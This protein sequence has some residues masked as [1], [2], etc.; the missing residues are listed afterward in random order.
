[1]DELRAKL[2]SDELGQH[3]MDVE[4]LLQKHAL[5]E[6]DLNIIADHVQNV[7]RQAERFSRDDTEGYKPVDPAVVRERMQFLEQR[8]K[9]LLE[10]A[11]ARKA[12]LEDNKRLCQFNWDLTDLETHFK[13]QEQVDILPYLFLKLKNNFRF[14]PKKIPV[15]IYSLLTAFLPN[16]KMPRITLPIWAEH[17]MIYNN[18]DNNWLMNKYL[19]V[20]QF[21]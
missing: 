20:D 15:E 13:E 19:E 2:D 18:K 5:L 4:E 14:L 10:L 11:A 1:M 17:L 8:Y 7:N 21:L 9:E 6:S 3:L 16:T 12:R